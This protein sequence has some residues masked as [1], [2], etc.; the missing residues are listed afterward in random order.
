MWKQIPCA[1][2]SSCSTDLNGEGTKK[3]CEWCELCMCV[4]GV[5]KW[6]KPAAPLRN[7]EIMYLL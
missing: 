5:S 3:G 2:Y 1:V 7:E 6:I 4:K